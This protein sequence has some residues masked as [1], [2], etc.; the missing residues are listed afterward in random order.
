MDIYIFD[1]SFVS[2]LLIKINTIINIIAN[3]Y[4]LIKTNNNIIIIK[5]INY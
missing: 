1:C 3:I 4:I 5:N 2:I